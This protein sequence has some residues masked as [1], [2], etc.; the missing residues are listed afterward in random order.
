MVQPIPL[1]DT[2][3]RSVESRVET[4]AF[5]L[6]CTKQARIFEFVAESPTDK[7]TW[8]ESLRTASADAPP[9][10]D[11][12]IRD[13]QAE[14][15]NALVAGA[16]TSNAPRLSMVGTGPA[17]VANSAARTT[18]ATVELSKEGATGGPSVATPAAV[19][20]ANAAAEAIIAAAAQP[21]ARR[22]SNA[23]SLLDTTL[24]QQAT[25]PVPA[26]EATPLANDGVQA[27]LHLLPVA[28]A[29]ADSC[30]SAALPT[31]VAGSRPDVLAAPATVALA[32]AGP[33]MVAAP[34]STDATTPAVVKERSDATLAAQERARSPEPSRAAEA[35]VRPTAQVADSRA[36][37]PVFTD[38]Q[39]S[40]NL[41]I[42]DII[43]QLKEK[44]ELMDSIAKAKDALAHQLEMLRLA[45]PQAADRDADAKSGARNASHD[46]P[47]SVAKPAVISTMRASDRAARR[48]SYAGAGPVNTTQTA[49]K[50]RHVQLRA[51]TLESVNEPS[52]SSDKNDKD[53]LP[54]TR[55]A[56]EPQGLLSDSSDESDGEVTDDL[57]AITDA[58]ELRRRL[59][60]ALRK[61]RKRDGKI[62]ELRNTI[63]GLRV[64]SREDSLRRS[65]SQLALRSGTAPSPVRSLADRDSPLSVQDRFLALHGPFR[66]VAAASMD[67]SRT[68]SDA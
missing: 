38:M 50:A 36:E 45:N 37:E 40:S 67:V 8:M 20:A 14:F 61:L 30:T 15:L 51:S 18:P 10:E 2:L 68:S 60:R 57:D 64:S 44:E 13:A 9:L 46:E 33:V 63:A 39:E 4:N 42:L 7:T 48:R 26:P 34:A 25:G 62:L 6:V 41:A 23:G 31:S 3:V 32:D 65:I 43:Q 52:A 35:A 22:S 19:E 29:A 11:L 24:P 53:N 28:P 58:G 56:S 55:P 1:Q 27:T 17:P 16:S 5:F 47:A 21:P 59:R 49:P 66:A 12:R 54:V